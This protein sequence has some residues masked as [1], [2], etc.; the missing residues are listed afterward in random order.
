MRSKSKTSS[1]NEGNAET[2]KKSD[3]N[4]PRKSQTVEHRGD[5]DR[6]SKSLQKTSTKTQSS[7]NTI[8]P[9][10]GSSQV[11]TVKQ[12]SSTSKSSPLNAS[13]SNSLTKKSTTSKIRSE[14][15]L[16]SSDD[17]T[18]KKRKSR[19][20][21]G[22]SEKRGQSTIYMPKSTASKLN[23]KS[24]EKIAH[25]TSR[26]KEKSQD[27]PA[28]DRTKTRLSSRERKKSRTL[29]PSEVRMLHSAVR[30]LDVI[31]KVGQKKVSGSR[32]HTQA[33]SEADY[34][35]EDDFEVRK[36]KKE[37]LNEIYKMNIILLCFVFQDY[38][39]DFQEC[40]D[41]DT[42]SI[43]EKSDSSNSELEPIELQM[44]EKVLFYIYFTY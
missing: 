2:S 36:K 24:N 41:S 43:S 33:D 26:E 6:V 31:E 39:S 14:I 8:K 30:R 15:V 17:G 34:D 7:R 32:S 11:K 40:T 1:S 18:I 9:S 44:R 38:E 29:S 35:Y 22:L 19:E 21:A 12:V 28:P 10:V 42:P 27:F 13:S 20:Q 25:R 5:G 16:K 37:I 4:F 3:S 23:T